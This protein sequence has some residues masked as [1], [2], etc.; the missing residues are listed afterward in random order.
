MEADGLLT[1]VWNCAVIFR[2]RAGKLGM[3][4]ITKRFDSNMLAEM[5]EQNESV[6]PLGVPIT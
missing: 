5:R 6:L 1:S 4:L 2:P 3:L